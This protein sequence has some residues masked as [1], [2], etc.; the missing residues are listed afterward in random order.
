MLE[1]LVENLNFDVKVG[2]F[3][4]I[5]S[6]STVLYK[7]LLI[8]FL[9]SWIADYF[10]IKRLVKRKENLKPHSTPEHPNVNWDVLV[11]NFVSNFEFFD[12]WRTC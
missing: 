10:K 1:V 8:H 2:S 11:T 6:L 4:C 12:C 5:F 9:V 3:N 7:I